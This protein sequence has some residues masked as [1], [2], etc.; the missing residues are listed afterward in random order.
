MF[1][2]YQPPIDLRTGKIFSVEALLHSKRPV[3]GMITP[4]KFIPMAK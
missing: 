4:N 3:M 1:F 2:D